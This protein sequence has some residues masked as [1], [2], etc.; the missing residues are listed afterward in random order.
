MKRYQLLLLT[1]LTVLAVAVSSR[2]ILRAALLWPPPVNISAV[3]PPLTSLE[4]PRI[5]GSEGTIFESF[6]TLG[7][8][9]K[10]FKER[11]GRVTDEREKYLRTPSTWS[12]TV[13]QVDS[14]LRE[15]TALAV[16]LPGWHY[17]HEIQ[18]LFGRTSIR[19][20]RPVLFESFSGVLAE[21]LR[22]YECKLLELGDGAIA[23]VHR[24]DDMPPGTKFCC[25]ESVCVAVTA[26][27]ACSGAP[28][29]HPQCGG[30]CDVQVSPADYA[31]RPVRFVELLEA[32]R[33]RARAAVERTLLTLR[34]FETHHAIAKELL[35]YERASLD[36]KN[37]MSL[38]ADATSCMP[39]MWDPVTSVHDRK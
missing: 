38:L 22:E 7:D 17:Q 24:N 37:E 31:G 18:S 16:D 8:T 1:L 9:V 28:T 12:C 14:S 13:A 10:I 4:N 39:K 30:I 2:L 23:A 20:L 5:C 34:S 19:T 3:T 15:L 11:A 21:L 33:N 32:E 29:E 27:T 35:C 26:Q 36:L 6:T 25:E